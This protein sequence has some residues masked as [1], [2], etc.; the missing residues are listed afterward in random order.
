[1]TDT[2][3]LLELR[4]VTKRF[5]GVTALTGVD[6]DVRTGEVHALIGENGAGKSTLLRVLAGATAPD[7]G[8]VR[9]DGE[10]ADFRGPGDALARGVTVIY[11]ELTLVPH[12]SVAENLFLGIEPARGGIVDRGA[13][14]RGASEALE[15]VGLAA[16]P[17]APVARLSVAQQQMV[18]MAR[19]LVRDARLLALDEPTATLTPH[20]VDRLF[21]RVDRLRAAGA[22]IVFVSHRLDEVRRV[23]DRVTV[24]RDGERV[25]TG[26][27]TE[28]D[29]AALVRAMVGRDVEYPRQPA[30]GPPAEPPLLEAEGLTRE[31]AFRDVSLRLRRGEIVGLAGLVGA[32]R[33]EVARVLAGAD[34]PDAGGMRLGG[35]PFRPRS[36]R[37]ALRRGV[38]Y[39]PEDR[40][41]DG[42]VPR[43][44]VREN[45]TLSVLGRF[46]RGGVVRRRAEAA[47][48]RAAVEEVDLRPPEIERPARTLSGGNQQKVV[49]ARGLMAE[50][51]VLLFDEPTRGVDIGA[52]A[53]LHRQIRALA[54]GGRAVLVISSELPELLALADRVVVVREGRVTGRL[55][56]EAMTAEGI[57]A[58][59]VAG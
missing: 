34:R 28:R 23:A 49:V 11:Q 24:L 29:D 45:V 46:T 18:E 31:P 39:F 17:G 8:E 27:A 14:R 52:K 3:P 42:L 58:L 47:A 59:A 13:M 41:R 10:P 4:G 48:A 33:T 19:A 53:E 44:T 1:V 20:E 21:E 32:G 54:D 51:R 7:V 55:A 30:A 6:F 5:P 16:D 22:G 56:G 37:E 35:E 50:A 38:V 12:L 57:M 2:P 43:L 25:W 26:P 9:V 36:P 15:Q 40:K